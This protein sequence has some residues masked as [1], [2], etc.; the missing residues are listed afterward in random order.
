MLKMSVLEKLLSEDTDENDIESKNSV[1]DSI[2]AE[3]RIPEETKRVVRQ[4]RRHRPGFF[5]TLARVAFEVWTTISHIKIN[6]YRI[7]NI[8]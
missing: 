7:C 2:M 1:E 5:Y 8:M 6:A 4:V 3:T